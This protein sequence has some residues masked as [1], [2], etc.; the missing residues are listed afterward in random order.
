M[1]APQ[2]LQYSEVQ[3]NV[4]L[5]FGVLAAMYFTA[6][7]DAAPN[8]RRPTAPHSYSNLLR[9]PDEPSY[10][11]AEHTDLLQQATTGGRG[12]TDHCHIKA[13]HTDTLGNKHAW[14]NMQTK[15]RPGCNQSASVPSA[16]L[17]LGLYSS[18]SAL[19]EDTSAG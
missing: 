19:P 9:T 7:S 3:V 13:L 14:N 5:T 2:P 12:I 11:S 15:A 16:G 8:A 4:K 1:S 18:L 10:K 6:I 17:H